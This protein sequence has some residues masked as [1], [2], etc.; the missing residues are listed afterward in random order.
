MNVHFPVSVQ[1][2]TFVLFNFYNYIEYG[3]FFYCLEDE[4]HFVYMY[5][6]IYVHEVN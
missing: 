6:S 5:D 2:N 1:Y 4:D 3:V